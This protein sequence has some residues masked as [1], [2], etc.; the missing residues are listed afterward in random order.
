MASSRRSHDF[1][2]SPGGVGPLL[3]APARV[4]DRQAHPEVGS[5]FP[6]GIRRSQP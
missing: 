5:L 2:N 4:P 6:S 3:V 1:A